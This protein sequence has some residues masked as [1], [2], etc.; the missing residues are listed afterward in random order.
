MEPVTLRYLQGKAILQEDAITIERNVYPRPTLQQIPF[1]Q[2]A[3]I[4]HTSAML[5][6][7]LSITIQLMDTTTLNLKVVSPLDGARQLV[8]TV[9]AYL[10]ARATETPAVVEGTVVAGAVGEGAVTPSPA[11]PAPQAA[12]QA[13][14]QIVVVAAA[15][16]PPAPPEQMIKIYRGPDCAKHFQKEAKKLARKGWRVQSQTYGGQAK[17]GAALFIGLAAARKPNEM[18]VVYVRN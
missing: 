16:A 10:G 9:E 7:A 15:S 3:S 5:G 11:T 13:A 14:A 1:S 18:T 8:A 4:R 17:S 2:I 6:T 12:P